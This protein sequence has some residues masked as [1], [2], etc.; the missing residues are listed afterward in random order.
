MI[1]L[2][3]LV[4]PWVLW[5]VEQV[6]PFPALI[7]EA[8]KAVFVRRAHRFR[9]AVGW[10]LLFGLAEALLFLFNANLFMNLGGWWPRLFLTVPLHGVTAGTYYAL[11]K[12]WWLGLAVAVLI[13]AGFNQLVPG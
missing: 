6:L 7:E 10:G 12:H 3:L 4:L 8:A 1:E 11:R 5:F 13:H 9:Q 2:W